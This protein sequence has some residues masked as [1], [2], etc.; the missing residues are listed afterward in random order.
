MRGFRRGFEVSVGDRV[1][2]RERPNPR[3]PE[4]GDVAE[5]AQHAAEIAG[6]GAH[7]GSLAALAFERRGV[8]VV[9]HQA[10]HMDDDFAGVQ[11]DDLAVPREVVGALAGD[12]DLEPLAGLDLV[13]DIG[14]SRCLQPER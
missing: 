7:I 12:L 10:Q 2:E 3:A 8:G 11:F 5:A 6:D 14:E 1:V 13:G 9:R 4:R